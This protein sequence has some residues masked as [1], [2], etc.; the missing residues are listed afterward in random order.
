LRPLSDLSE[1][2]FGLL[3]LTGLG[4]L[5][6]FVQKNACA[7]DVADGNEFFRELNFL[8]Q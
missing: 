1:Q 5:D 2:L 4:A 6:N 3:Q 7:D 8:I